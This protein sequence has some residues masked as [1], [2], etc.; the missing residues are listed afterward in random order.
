MKIAPKS[1]QPILHTTLQKSCYS[2]L[3]SYKVADFIL[4][5]GSKVHFYEKPKG[6][7]SANVNIFKFLIRAILKIYVSNGNYKNSEMS[8]L[9]KKKFAHLAASN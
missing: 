9:F 4:S 6:N 2:L 1:K 5:D 7:P 3:A 8:T